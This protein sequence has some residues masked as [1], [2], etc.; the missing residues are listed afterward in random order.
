MILEEM[1]ALEDDIE[2]KASTYHYLGL[3]DK[4]IVTL[5]HWIDTLEE[6]IE[7][8]RSTD[9]DMEFEE[10]LSRLSNRLKSELGHRMSKLFP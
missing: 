9:M 4:H 1:K 10:E 5:F 2:S 6:L 7:E 8:V 3:R